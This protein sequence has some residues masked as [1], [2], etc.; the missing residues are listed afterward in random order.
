MNLMRGFEDV[1]SM[2]STGC[3]FCLILSAICYFLD[4][5]YPN[6]SKKDNNLMY[7]ILCMISISIVSA[8][9]YIMCYVLFLEALFYIFGMTIAIC[10]CIYKVIVRRKRKLSNKDFSINGLCLADKFSE[11]TSRMILG[12]IK[13]NDYV[14]SA[15]GI[16]KSRM[17]YYFDDSCINVCNGKIYHF[18]TFKKGISS[19]RGIV[20]GLSTL[21]DV[22]Q[23]Y[24]NA[25]EIRLP[26]TVGNIEP[27]IEYYCIYKNKNIFD[28]DQDREL[29][30]GVDKKG[31]IIYMSVSMDELYLYY[32]SK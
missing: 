31:L 11:D 4:K 30:F 23:L 27:A 28:H 22:K 32:D 9:Y 17:T 1:F 25:N 3:Y 2:I 13:R 6:L 10:Y 8:I 5:F 20:I 18:S 21:S 16:D 29:E 7:M 14:R 12:E 26:L 19:S 24:G 15:S